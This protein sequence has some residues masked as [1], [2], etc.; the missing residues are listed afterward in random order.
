MTIL[1][2]PLVT[3]K[4][5]EEQC[6]EIWGWMD[7]LGLKVVVVGAGM[8]ERLRQIGFNMDRVEVVPMLKV[9]PSWEMPQADQMMTGP[10][11]KG[12]RNRWGNI[13]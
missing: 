4:T 11:S 9:P 3:P 5:N 6:A 8:G 7:S 10:V 12:P 13:K 1:N 2:D